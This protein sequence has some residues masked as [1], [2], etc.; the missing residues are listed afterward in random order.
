MSRASLHIF[1]VTVVLLLASILA[2]GFPD[3]PVTGP[4]F[5]SR[6][7]RVVSRRSGRSAKWRRFGALAAACSV[8]RGRL[9]RERAGVHPED[10]PEVTVG[11]LE[12]APCT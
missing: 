12:A 10:F 4:S 5:G 11:I 6:D 7:N 1:L 9:L 3:G 2:M 8:K